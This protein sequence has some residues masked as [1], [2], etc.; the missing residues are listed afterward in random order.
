MAFTDLQRMAWPCVLTV[1][2][3]GSRVLHCTERPI[4]GLVLIGSP[5]RGPHRTPRVRHH[6]LL[7]ILLKIIHLELC[8][9]SLYFT[10]SRAT[11][12]LAAMHLHSKSTSRTRYIILTSIG[13]L[14]LT[15]VFRRVTGGAIRSASAHISVRHF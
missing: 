15:Y 5:C 3:V 6:F 4:H 14:G 7:S 9:S 8:A 11:S 2:C 13:V 10:D 12:Q 1:H